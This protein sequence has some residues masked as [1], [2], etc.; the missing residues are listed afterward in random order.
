VSLQYDAPDGTH[1]EELLTFPAAK[2]FAARERCDVKIGEN[3]FSG[4]L[5]AYTIR[6]TGKQVSAELT[7]TGRVP[8]WRP[9]TGQIFFGEHDE[10]FFAWLPSVPE[11]SVEG[12]LTING[13]SQRITG[14]GYHDHNWGNVSMLRLMNHW[15]WGR[16]KIGEYTVISSF[17]TAEKKYGYRTFP[18]FLLAKN[19]IMVA[20]ST[21][22]SPAFFA[23]VRASR[24]RDQEAGSR[25]VGIRS[26]QRKRA[27]RRYLPPRKGYPAHAVCRYASPARPAARQ[28]D[29]FFRRVPALYRHGEPGAFCRR[30]TCRAGFRL[31]HLGIDVLWAYAEQLICA[32]NTIRF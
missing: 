5:H 11:G 24:R 16:A 12:E 13:Q 28:T 32:E 8:A 18:V 23:V 1:Y 15:Y 14:T 22:D 29:W 20:Q 31:R 25:R 30:R 17:I 10:H 4:D 2:F 21:L 6:L 19:G 3:V 26:H 27:V 9:G 7:L